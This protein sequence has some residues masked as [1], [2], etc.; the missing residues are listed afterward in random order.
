[1]THPVDAVRARALR[2]L[3]QLAG[4]DAPVAS[5]LPLLRDRSAR[6]VRAAADLLRPVAAELPDGLARSLLADENRTAV[7]RAGYRLLH[8]PDPVA[9]LLVHLRVAADPDPRLAV[10][11]AADAVTLLRRAATTARLRPDPATRAELLALAHEVTDR[12]G[13]DRLDLLHR[14]TVGG[15]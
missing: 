5:V 13:P 7:R 2:G 14:A 9:R 4:A 3:R 12:I 8:E 1:M 6:V 10:R 11:A 15:E